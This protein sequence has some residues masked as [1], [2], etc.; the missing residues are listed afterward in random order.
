MFGGLFTFG[1]KRICGTPIENAIVQR[2]SEG[3]AQLAIGVFYIGF[4][5]VLTNR[6]DKVERLSMNRFV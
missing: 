6:I 3:K 2:L 5:L 4:F 1:L